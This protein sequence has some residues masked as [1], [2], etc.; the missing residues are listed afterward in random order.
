MLVSCGDSDHKYAN[1]ERPPTPIVVSAAINDQ[2]VIVSPRKFGAGPITLIISNQSSAS[3]QVT[4]ETDDQPGDSGPGQK[5]IATGPINPRETA[6]VKG[7]VVEGT[8]A[9]RVGG[10]GVKP[11]TI[12]V[13]KERPTSQNDLL[14]P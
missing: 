12:L 8:Y 3:Q 9:L 5:A 2:S 14:Q 6:S 1:A 4:L 10:D 13:G 11:A 7:Q